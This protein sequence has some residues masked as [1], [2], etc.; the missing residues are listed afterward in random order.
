MRDAKGKYLI[1]G[2]YDDV[3]VPSEAALKAAK[4]L[5]RDPDAY[6]KQS[7]IPI[8]VKNKINL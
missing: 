7:G 2:F 5:N 8:L 6:M 3:F 4:E 1:E